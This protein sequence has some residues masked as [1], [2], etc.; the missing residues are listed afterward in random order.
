MSVEAV[1]GISELVLAS[2]FAVQFLVVIL[3]G[4]VI[5]HN[6][7]EY[8]SYINDRKATARSLT[9]QFAESQLNT[10]LNMAIE[11]ATA[12]MHGY[13]GGQMTQED[14]LELLA[15]TIASSD[16]LNVKVKNKIKEYIRDTGYYGL[17]KK[18]DKC[19]TAKELYESKIRERATE[20]RAISQ[21]TV[22]NVFRP[23][24]PLVG[25]AEKRFSYSD[26]IKIYEKIIKRHIQEVDQEVDDIRAK[27]YLLFP[28]VYKIFEYNHKDR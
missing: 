26:G 13:G 7:T 20:L 2:G 27:G 17:S 25:F 12:L 1:L 10:I 9:Y 21:A 15:Y 19:V 4:A 3:V 18:M 5:I 11:N 8:L 24:S 14:R 22:A 23:D 28:F 16:S 6:I